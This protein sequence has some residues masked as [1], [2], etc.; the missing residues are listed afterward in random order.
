ML[1]LITV[2]AETG[3]LFAFFIALAV[4]AVLVYFHTEAPINISEIAIASLFIFLAVTQVLYWLAEIKNRHIESKWL[5]VFST[6]ASVAWIICLIGFIW[7]ESS[8]VSPP[9]IIYALFGIIVMGHLEHL[10]T[11]LP[12]CF[13]KFRNEM[14]IDQAE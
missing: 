5:N 14:L 13:E 3:R 6:I 10:I 12:L 11:A 7:I 2:I 9:W 1:F 8:S 4:P